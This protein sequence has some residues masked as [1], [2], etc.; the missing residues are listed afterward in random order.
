MARKKEAKVESGVEAAPTDAEV[1]PEPTIEEGTDAPV[2]ETD[3]LDAD[4][5]PSQQMPDASSLVAMAGMHMETEPLVRV[6]VS[7]FDMHAWRSMGLVADHS[8]EVKKDLAA[9]QT[10]IDCLA[11]LLGKIERSLED[12][13]RRDIQ[14]RLTDLRMNFV[15]K[16]REG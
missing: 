2:E 7:V 6:L 10:A 11:F 9:A 5:Q 12:G 1:Q 15:A 8:G 4:A 14:R 13:E 3:P 16:S